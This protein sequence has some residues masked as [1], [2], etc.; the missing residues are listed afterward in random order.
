[1]KPDSYYLVSSSEV[2]KIHEMIIDRLGGRK[3]IHSVALLESAINHPLMVIEYGN[4]QDCEIHNLT[5]VYF[6][7]IIKNHPFV[8]GNKR[9]ALL[10]ALTFIDRNGFE[11]TG[12]WS[13]L[14]DSLYELALDTA[15]S[16]RTIEEIGIFFMGIMKKK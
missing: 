4:D 14:Y 10:T 5:A 2:E 8:D 7:H 13:S 1:M 16:R 11:C 12:E 6:F 9:T 15:S 3:G